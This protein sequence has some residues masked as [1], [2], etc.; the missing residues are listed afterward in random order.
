MLNKKVT[1]V[2]PGWTINDDPRVVAAEEQRVAV[3]KSLR[4]AEARL[5][6]LQEAR[7]SQF[8]ILQAAAG[9]QELE[10]RLRER[11][12]AR[13]EAREAVR[14]ERKELHLRSYK[15][16]LK[17]REVVVDQLVAAEKLVRAPWSSACE[18]GV[19]LSVQPWWEDFN[20]K[21]EPTFTP[22]W[23][24]RRRSLKSLGLID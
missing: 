16:A 22:G 14:A 12:A 7:A 8:A 1:T 3:S 17:V 13:D 11:T 21:E 24:H 9:V 6:A 18:E 4:E 15:E 2:P 10:G 5:A 19:E 23:L 20:E